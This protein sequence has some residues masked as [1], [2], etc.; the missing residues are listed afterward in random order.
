MTGF[1][2]LRPAYP[3]TL[4][5]QVATELCAYGYV[6]THVCDTQEVDSYGTDKGPSEFWF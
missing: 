3:R 4:P 2:K 5:V 6:N 1:F